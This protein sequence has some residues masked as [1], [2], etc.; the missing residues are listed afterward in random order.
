MQQDKTR[1]STLLTYYEE[2]KVNMKVNNNDKNYA[3]SILNMIFVQV[4]KTE[5]G[6]YISNKKLHLFW[7]K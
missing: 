6:L 7:N 2:S 4:K 3:N 5:H 1:D